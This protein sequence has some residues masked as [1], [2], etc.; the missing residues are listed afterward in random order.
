MFRSALSLDLIR[1]IN[2]IFIDI[3]SCRNWLIRFLIVVWIQD[4]SRETSS[5][6]TSHTSNIFAPM[7]ADVEAW[8]TLSNITRHQTH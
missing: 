2:L 4:I 7:S 5:S 3:L 1:E 6:D 8:M